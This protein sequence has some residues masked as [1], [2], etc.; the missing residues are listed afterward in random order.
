MRVLIAEDNLLERRMLETAVELLGHD[1]RSAADG[2]EAWRLYQEQGADVIISDWVMPGLDGQELC[3]RVRAQQQM[4]A[5]GGDE[6]SLTDPGAAVGGSDSLSG[7]EL[8][9]TP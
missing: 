9:T 1:C 4:R 3:Q 7:D 2:A 6:G 8:R 5:P